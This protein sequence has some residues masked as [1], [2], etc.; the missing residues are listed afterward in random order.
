MRWVTTLLAITLLCCGERERAPAGP[1]ASPPSRAA[2]PAAAQTAASE[3]KQ[4][5]DTR[6][7]TCHGV[8]GAGDGPGSAALEPKPRNFGDA[9]WQASISDEQLEKAI[10][11]GG[12][13]VGKSP[14]MPGNPDLMS[15]P[16]VVR[17]LVAQL[18]GLERR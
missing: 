1:A 12:A 13:A 15:K 4:I 9:A 8:A 14:T 10:L 18:R 6:C 5:F 16:E 2:A 17:A 11:Y 7:V 3:A